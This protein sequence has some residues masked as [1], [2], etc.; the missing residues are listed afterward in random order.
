MFACNDS[1]KHNTAV[2]VIH[3]NAKLKRAKLKISKR[4]LTTT[5]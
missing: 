1:R 3:L 5:P 4:V 2:V